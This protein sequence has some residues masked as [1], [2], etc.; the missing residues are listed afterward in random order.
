MARAMVRAA[1]SHQV[2]RF[3]GAAVFARFNVVHINE[4]DVVTTWRLAAMLVSA[5]HGASQSGRHVLPRAWSGCVRRRRRRRYVIADAGAHV[6][7]AELLPIAA[8][9][10][11][12]VSRD[13]DGLPAA[14]FS[15][16]ALCA[17]CQ[18]DLVAGAAV[19]AGPTEHV[20]RHE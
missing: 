4:M 12:D 18:L 5:Q 10:L 17:N 9:H 13:I 16:L 7:V 11:D 2:V 15:S 19:I 14:L 20:P 1:Q 3:V 6:G 8:R